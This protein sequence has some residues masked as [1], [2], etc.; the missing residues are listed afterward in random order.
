MNLAQ[1]SPLLCS[2]ARGGRGDADGTRKLLNSILQLDSKN[3]RV[4]VPPVCVERLGVR[5]AVKS[6]GPD[7]NGVGC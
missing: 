6:H 2:P 3:G 5:R 1:P 7:R 4:L